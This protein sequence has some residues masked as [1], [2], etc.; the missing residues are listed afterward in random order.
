MTA[1]PSDRAPHPPREGRRVVL[2]RACHRPLYDLESRA[3]GYGPECKD[4]IP[5]PERHGEQDALPGL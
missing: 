3:L 1:E 2:C 5:D 4:R